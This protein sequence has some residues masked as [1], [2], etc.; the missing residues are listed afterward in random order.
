MVR[1]IIKLKEYYYIWSSVVD[2]PVTDSLDLDQLNEFIKRTEGEEGL[3]ELPSRLQRVE[4]KG[5]SAFNYSSVAELISSQ[6]R[7]RP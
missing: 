2:A 3:R 1:Y 4:E 7:T 5:T 6:I